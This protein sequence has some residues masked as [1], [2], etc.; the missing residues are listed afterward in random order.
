MTVILVSTSTKLMSCL[1]WARS[2]YPSSSPTCLK[3]SLPTSSTRNDGSDPMMMIMMIMMI[4]MTI[5]MMVVMTVMMILTMT[6]TMMMMMMMIVMM[7]MMITTTQYL[8]YVKERFFWYFTLID[9]LNT[10]SSR[11]VEYFE[12]IGDL[13]I[14]TSLRTKDA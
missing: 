6:M 2:R 8:K 11:P 7:M 14:S 10:C 5:M 12:H 3:I 1:K 4:I 9:H 13:S